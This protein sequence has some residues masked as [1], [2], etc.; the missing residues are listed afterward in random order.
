MAN[1]QYF[2]L[3]TNGATKEEKNAAYKKWKA[4]TF[5]FKEFDS[6]ADAESHLATLGNPPELR[7]GQFMYP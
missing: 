3:M 6:R 5:C 2:G 1:G 4:E 7:V